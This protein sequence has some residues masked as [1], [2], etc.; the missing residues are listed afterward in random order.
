MIVLGIETATA[1]GGVAIGGPQ[2]VLASSDLVHGRRHVE[3]LAPSIDFVCQQ[4]GIDI[5]TI[6]LVAVDTGPGTFTG[7]RV[8]VA[9]AKAIMHARGISAVGVS[10]LDLVA[11][12]TRLTRKRIVSVLDAL[13]EEVFWAAYES[14]GT[15][16][17]RVIEP[18]VAKPQD[19]VRELAES[20][21]ECLVAGDGAERYRALFTPLGHVELAGPAFQYPSAAA[22]V[23]IA[24]V[25]VRCGES[26]RNASLDLM[27]LREPYIHPKRRND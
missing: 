23:E 21:Q 25:R 22:L 12:A 4:T 3:T 16:V 26:E 7:L 6:D 11:H 15:G 18:S 27:Y 19:V 14:T 13:R 10:S 24:S 20:G 5:N 8:G 2:G 9:T 17:R 1:R